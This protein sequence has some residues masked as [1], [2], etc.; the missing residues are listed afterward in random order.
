MVSYP[1]LGNTSTH[2]YMNLGLDTR[3]SSDVQDAISMLGLDKDYQDYLR[4]LPVGHAMVLMRRSTW[5]KPFVASFEHMKIKKGLIKDDDVAR[6]M[7]EKLGIVVEEEQEQTPDATQLEIINAIG[8][9][10][11]VFT[12]QLY[13]PLKLSGT[14]FKEKISSLLRN[15]TIGVREVRIEKTKANYYYLTEKGE[16]IFGENFSVK[17]KKFDIIDK[18]KEI[19]AS[20]GWQ[21]EQEGNSFT[22]T[23]ADKSIMLT[24]LDSMD[25]QKIE[26]SVSEGS[27]YI[28]ATAEIRNVLLQ[29]ASKTL[30]AERTKIS[31]ALFE[32]FPTAGFMD[33]VF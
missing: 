16:K 17:Q 33:F 3:Y 26:K 19:F 28:C 9:G 27:F 29:S 2:V 21:H 8:A 25:R 24:I 22:I 10:K 13:K 1:A 6:A 15:G 23:T 11:G 30:G 31:V 4:R 5:T 18:T 14:A 12:S 32:D 20:L 7:N